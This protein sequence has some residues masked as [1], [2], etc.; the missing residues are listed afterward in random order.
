ME[1]KKFDNANDDIYY[2]IVVYWWE[3]AMHISQI[4][5]F[6]STISQIIENSKVCQYCTSCFKIFH[7]N[8]VF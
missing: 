2:V 7:D 4:F 6:T 3:E 5:N 8:M 1:L